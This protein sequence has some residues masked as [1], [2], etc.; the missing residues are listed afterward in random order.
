MAI[1]FTRVS[2]QE[3]LKE[4]LVLQEQN[5]ATNLTEKEIEKEGFVTV[6]HTLDL[7][8]K[9]N[10]VCPHIIAKD[11]GRVIGYALCMHPDFSREIPVLL[12][13]FEQIREVVPKEQLYMVMGQVCI[14]KAYRGKGIFR[15]LY[16]TMKRS[17]NSSF[18]LIVTEVD[19][20]NQRSLNAHLA[21]GFNTIKKYQSDGRDW[22]LIAL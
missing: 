13:M 20:R 4:I 1:E 7:L 11:K 5:L 19:G 21:I 3:E 17:L 15:G 22:Y 16:K 10:M 14:D 6:T 2:R 18:E 9:M 8:S 12:S